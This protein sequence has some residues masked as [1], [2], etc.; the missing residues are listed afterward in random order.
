MSLIGLSHHWSSNN[1]KRTLYA[2]QQYNQLNK[3]QEVFSHFESNKAS[4]HRATGEQLSKYLPQ[5]SEASVRTLP[6]SPHSPA[7]TYPT[8]YF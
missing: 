4:P 3:H 1:A 5:L 7:I 6:T 2:F 8:C